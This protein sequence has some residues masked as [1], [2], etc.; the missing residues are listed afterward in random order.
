MVLSNILEILKNNNIEF[1]L[2]SNHSISNDL[3]FRPASLKNIIDNGI[4]F[5]QIEKTNFNT[6]IKD[7]IIITNQIL[8]SGNHE[9][10]VDNPQLVHYK[11][12]QCFVGVKAV[13]IHP[14]AIISEKAIIGKDVSIGPFSVIGNCVIG[15]RVCIKNHVVIEDNVTINND[16]FIDSNSVIGAGGLAWIWD[17]DGTRIMQPQLGGVV[18]EENCLI[19][20][21]VTIVRGSLSE[22]TRIGSCTVIAHGTKIGHGSQ[23]GTNIHM[24]NNVSLAGNAIIGDFSF[25]GSGSVVSSNIKIPHH[26]IVGAGALVNKNFEEEY[27]TIA[28]VPACIIKRENFKDKPNGAPKPF[29]K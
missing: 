26:T 10:I 9:I 16:C 22:N 6:D 7:S 24:A 21:D 15:D 23:I 18:I 3:S 19:A 17:A 4:Y 27:I 2:I 29:K 14:T 28:G 20:T 11:L 12:T 1:V 13:G 5:I 25:L 8:K